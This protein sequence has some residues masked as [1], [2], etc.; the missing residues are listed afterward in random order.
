MDNTQ[1]LIEQLRENY[2]KEIEKGSLSPDFDFK[3]YAIHI[4]Y[5]NVVAM[6]KELLSFQQSLYVGLHK[7]SKEEHTDN[8]LLCTICQKSDELRSLVEIKNEIFS[9]IFDIEEYKKRIVE[10]GV[11]QE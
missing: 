4:A 3:D 9:K 5:L 8:N 1:Q 7:L 10:E 2:L 11:P 6:E